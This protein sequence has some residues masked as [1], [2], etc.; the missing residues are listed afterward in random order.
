MLHEISLGSF[1]VWIPQQV[2]GRVLPW[3]GLLWKKRSDPAKKQVESG[4][5][6]KKAGWEAARKQ[7]SLEVF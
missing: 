6:C 4:G 1:H 7:V 5:S 3:R 2:T